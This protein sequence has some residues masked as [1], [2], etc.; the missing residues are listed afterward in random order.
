MKIRKLGNIVF[1]AITLIVFGAGTI[2]TAIHRADFNGS[3]ASRQNILAVAS[4]CFLTVGEL[5]FVFIHALLDSRELW[6][7]MAAYTL[8]LLLVSTITY[9]TYTEAIA[10]LSEGNMTAKAKIIDDFGTKQQQNARS[11]RAE[12]TA[13]IVS[14]KTLQDT[15]KDF[16]APSFG[17]FALNFFV[18]LFVLLTGTLIQPREAWKRKRGNVMSD[19][20]RVAAEK[21]IGF[22]LPQGATAYDDGKGSSIVIKNG[23]EYIATVSKRKIGL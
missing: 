12:S 1:F 3:I 13:I 20:V 15:L 21:Q 23:R 2:F 10:F 8:S 14:Q 7:R 17:P 19:D 11:K 4:A 16:S 18:G 6:R 5:A 9:A 22:A